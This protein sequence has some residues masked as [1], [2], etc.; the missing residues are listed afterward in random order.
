M[1]VGSRCSLTHATCNLSEYNF[2]LQNR[3]SSHNLHCFDHGPKTITCCRDFCSDLF[4]LSPLPSSTPMVYSQYSCHHEPLKQKS[5]LCSEP[6]G[7][8]HLGLIQ[9]GLYTLT[10]SPSSSPISLSSLL[11]LSFSLHSSL[12]CAPASGPL[13]WLAPLPGML[14]P[15]ICSAHSLTSFRQLLKSHLLSEPYPP[16]LTIAT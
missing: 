11:P 15:N 9:S 13:H 16:P 3:A 8:S 10:C 12:C 4:T 7:R 2:K 1:A 6:S 14:F 5:L